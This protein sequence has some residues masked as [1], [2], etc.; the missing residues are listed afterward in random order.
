MIHLLRVSHA[1]EFE[2]QNYA[3]IAKELDI[4]VITSHHPLTSISLPHIPLWSPT[5]LPHFPFRRQLLNRLIGGEQWL[6]G[7]EKYLISKR[8]HELIHDVIHTAETYTPYTH[9]AVRLRRKG[10]VKK[11]V[12]TCWETIP[13]NNEK[14]ARLRKW[15]QEAYKYVDLFH[16]PTER[17]KQT[18]ITEGVDPHKIIVIPYGVDLT[19][20]HPSD[21]QGQ[22]L[23]VKKK[24][25]VL[26]VA[27][28][29]YEKGIDIFHQ[30][31]DELSSIADFRLVSGAKYQQMPRIY[32][33]ADL[34]FLPSR[35]T[36]TWEEQYGMALVEAMACGLPIVTTSTGAIP[37]VIGDAGITYPVCDM[38]KMVKTTKDLLNNQAKLKYYSALSL[39]RATRLYDSRKVALQLAKLYC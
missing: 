12:C 25:V 9:Q 21:L 34:F 14:F 20:F 32:Q 18:L 36:S 5:D 28:P 4:S 2:L 16:T 8:H 23:K 35:T 3:P 19:K 39:A 38:D 26:L 29:V 7:L 6:L 17:A 31:S 10:I 30:V 1:N 27:R 37:E 33:S 11:L 15:K 22:S 13:G 24:P